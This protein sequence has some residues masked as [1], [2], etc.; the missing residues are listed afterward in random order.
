MTMRRRFGRPRLLGTMAR[1]AVIAG[2][3]QAATSGM[4]RHEA[5]P[6][7]APNPAA[8]RG[9]GDIIAELEKLASLKSAGALT[10]D[11]FAAAKAKVLGPTA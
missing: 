2:T 10:D 4:Q 1:T 5:A 9:G 8:R 11:E 7:A 6:A 3:A